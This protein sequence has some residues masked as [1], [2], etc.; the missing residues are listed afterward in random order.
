MDTADGNTSGTI[1]H[2]E[3]FIDRKFI[4]GVVTQC[5][6]KLSKDF[7]EYA[8]EE[9]TL[10]KDKV[11]ENSH[12]CFEKLNSRLESE[13]SFLRDE[14]TNKNKIIELL[15]FDKN[16]THTSYTHGSTYQTEKNHGNREKDF[17]YPKKHASPIKNQ[18]SQQSNY[19][20][21]NR[22]DPL[23]NFDDTF[24]EINDE[25]PH[26]DHPDNDNQEKVKKGLANGNVTVRKKSKKKA[27][28]KESDKKRYVAVVGDS[29]LKEVKGHLLSTKKENVVVKSFSGATTKQM[30]DYVK[31]TLEME[32]DQ[33]IIH[34]GTNDL[35]KFE[36]NDT[37]IDNIMKLALHCH[38]VSGIPVVVSSLTCRDDNFRDRILPINNALRGRC[39]ER[40][41]GFIDNS[42]IKNF[43]L[44]RSKLHLNAKGTSLIA[45]N[46]KSVTSN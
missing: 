12:D 10:K 22:F 40:N 31:P 44:N 19:L 4:E 35:R 20:H 17:Q 32:P 29:I 9:I 24:N 13:V 21:Q 33:L 23:L 41:M 36:N 45:K 39:E 6:E 27:E 34:V 3:R 7:L 30:F 37:I 46:L 26:N 38:E 5:F 14:I 16:H 8:K 1:E 25:Q 2:T 42:N 28:K 11:V 15:I 43:H 18:S